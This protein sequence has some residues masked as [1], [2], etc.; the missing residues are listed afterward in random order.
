MFISHDLKVIA[1]LASKVIVMRQGKVVEAGP[2][3]EVFKAPK[4][5]Y[6]RA[7]FSAAFDLEITSPEVVAQ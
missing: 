4:N 2:A 1:A 7:L 5:E 3:T 6:T